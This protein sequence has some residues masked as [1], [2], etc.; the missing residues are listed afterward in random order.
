[1]E[2]SDL[3]GQKDLREYKGKKVIQETLV[4]RVQ[5]D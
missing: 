5:S 1:M 3:R 4:H 2:Q